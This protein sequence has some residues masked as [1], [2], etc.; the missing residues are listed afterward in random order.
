MHK[1]PPTKGKAN[2]RREKDN[3]DFEECATTAENVGVQPRSAPRRGA[4]QQAK[5]Q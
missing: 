5:A 1:T 3:E 4:K 2:Q